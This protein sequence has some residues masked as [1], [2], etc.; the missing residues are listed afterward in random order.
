M[1]LTKILP[2]DIDGLNLILG[3]GVPTVLRGGAT[4]HSAVVVIRGAPG[5]GKTPLGTQIAGSLARSLNVDVGYGCVELLPEELAAQHAGF[6]RAV[7]ERVV[8]FPISDPIPREGCRIFAAILALGDPG[9]PAAL[10]PALEKLR[11][12]IISHGGRP[13]VLVVDSLS[14]GY[15]LGPDTP[16]ELA[17]EVCKFAAAEGLL[18]I[19]LEES[20]DERP[21]VW[22]FAADVVLTLGLN[23]GDRTPAMPEPYERRLS[24]L[25]N[26]FGPSDPGP[27]AFTLAPREGV[28]VMP[29]PTAYLRASQLGQPITPQHPAASYEPWLGRTQVHASWPP[30]QGAS[31]LVFG[32]PLDQLY[33]A[34]EHFG[35]PPKPNRGS[36]V[37]LHLYHGSEGALPSALKNAV[38]VSLGDP[39][40]SQNAFLARAIAAIRQAQRP[41]QRVFLADLAALRLFRDAQGL[42]RAIVAL[43]SVLRRMEVPCIVLDHTMPTTDDSVRPG[44]GEFVDIQ[45][46]F[47]GNS[48]HAW[49]S[50]SPQSSVN[51]DIGTG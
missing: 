5:V 48:M 40:L 29:R 21:S 11:A 44:L 9:G 34:A 14:A 51:F 28:F 27:H 41:V 24:V 43:L 13:R 1:L 19:L 23:D 32:G 35:R 47:H 37:L 7:P 4:E 17:D 10:R 38:Q 25:K 46:R 2:T 39:Y 12:D 18:L 22:S 30:V 50:S 33:R 49:L 3:G 31:V 15:G 36:D 45:A 16:R 20:F 42:A 6:E 8:P 26:R